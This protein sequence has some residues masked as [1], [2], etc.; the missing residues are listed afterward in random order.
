MATKRKKTGKR[1]RGE[2]SVT[3]R[4]DGRWQTSMTLEGRKRKYF[5]GENQA[6]ALE[7]LHVAQEQQR[8]G[9]LA[10]G[11][12]QT[13]AQFFEDWLENVHRH[14]IRYNTYRIYRTHLK[15][16][17]LP[18]LGHIKLQNLTVYQIETLYG[19]LQQQG[20]KA[21]TIRSLHRM[22]SKALGDAVRWKRLS[23]NICNDVQQPSE[24]EFEMQLL[25]Q[26]QAKALIESVRGTPLEAIIP[27]AL[28]TALRGGEILG[29]LWSDID[30]E[31]KSLTVKRTAYRVVK[32]GMITSE[33]KTAKSKSKILLPQFVTDA[34]LLHRE[35]QELVRL[36]MGEKW[37]EHGLVFTNS[38]G[39]FMS[40][41][42]YLGNKFKQVLKKASLPDMR[43]H[44]L[45]H[46]SATILLEMGVHPKLVQNL[47]RHAKL[48]TTM[49]RYSHVRPKLQRKVM[50][51][52]DTLFQDK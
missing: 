9:K 26:E 39:K 8:Q 47:L 25:T 20:Y 4:K 22:L 32:Q 38:L 5:Y 19:K 16:R 10:R 42:H 7:K 12:Q 41:Q 1:A 35:R 13:V 36:K 2:G 29:L 37:E 49:D 11:R 23:H 48:A 45:R 21:E 34:L 27:L 6:E 24:E 52:L 51:D 40:R 15:L 3:L 31:E 17:V 46:S 43:F 50:D 30:F 18:T 33:P 28:G 14:K 44:D